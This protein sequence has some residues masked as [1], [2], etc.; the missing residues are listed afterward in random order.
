MG[1][2]GWKLERAGAL[3]FQMFLQSLFDEHQRHSPN[4]DGRGPVP[5]QTSHTALVK[6]YMC[7][8]VHVCSYLHDKYLYYALRTT[9]R[10]P[11]RKHK[12]FQKEKV[13]KIHFSFT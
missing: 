1:R 2:K 8:R 5:S 3:S 6:F 4:N 10:K 12:I 11:W 13:L 7:V 9:S